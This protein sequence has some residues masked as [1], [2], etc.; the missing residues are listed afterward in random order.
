MGLVTPGLG[1]LFWMTLS[2]VVVL[3]VLKKMAWQPIL[4]ALEERENTIQESLDAAKKAKADIQQLQSANEATIRQAHQERERILHEAKE[5]GD[6]YI[7]DAKKA[8]S[9]EAEKL[10]TEAKAS[11]LAEKNAAIKEIKNIVAELSVNIAEKVIGAELDDKKKQQKL[12]DGLLSEIK[13]S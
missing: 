9:E 11:I 6:K 4:S 5:L 10:K 13:L 7:A 3:F 1:L 2:F 12:V 8:A